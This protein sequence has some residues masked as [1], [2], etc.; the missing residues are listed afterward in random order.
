MSATEGTGHRGAS[1]GIARTT[2]SGPLV[3]LEPRDPAATGD[4]GTLAE[5]VLPAD[6]TAAGAAR[7]V[8]GHCLTGLVSR[9]IIGEA[10]LHGSEL[11][12]NSLRHDQADRGDVVLV[13]IYLGAEALRIEIENPGT[14]RGTVWFEM[15]RA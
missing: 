7:I 9:R 4:L 15:G 2:R 14:R 11:V 5:V 12:S 13:R 1:A 6:A 3:A 10:Q 8:I